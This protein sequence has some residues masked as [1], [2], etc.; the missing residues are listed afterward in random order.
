MLEGFVN[1]G[2]ALRRP[3][4]VAI[5]RAKALLVADDVGNSVWRVAPSEPT[6]AESRNVGTDIR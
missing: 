4:G 5:A 6:M 2:E 1:D 3:V